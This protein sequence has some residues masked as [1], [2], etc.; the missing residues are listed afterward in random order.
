MSTPL[1]LLS[2]GAH[3][4]DVFDQSGGTMAHHASRGDYVGCVVLT[5][6]AFG[7]ACQCAY[8]EGFISLNA[9]THHF[10]PVT[11][12]ALRTARYSDHENMARY[13]FHLRVD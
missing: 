12:H 5:H 11:E 10:L 6:G 3:P 1:R 7:T 13:S 8:A 4:A 2:I 9:E